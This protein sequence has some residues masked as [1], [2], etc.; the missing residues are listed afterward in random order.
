MSDTTSVP[1]SV[2]T[3]DTPGRLFI[4]CAIWAYEGWTGSFYPPKLPAARR[5]A[6]YGQK[7]TAV[8][9]N[10]TF[11]ALPKPETVDKWVAEVPDGFRFSPKFPKAITHQAGL[12]GAEHERTAFLHLLTRFG[13]KLGAAM[14]QLPPGFGPGRLDTLDRFLHSLPPEL[15]VA[16]E[17]RHLDWFT[18]ENAVRLNACLAQY[19]HVARVIF[20]GR[21]A[22]SSDAEEAVSAQ[23]RKPDVPVVPLATRREVLLRYISSPVWEENMPYLDDWTP[24]LATW[25]AQGHDVHFF[26]HCPKEELS[27]AIARDVYHRISTALVEKHAI[28]LPP[29]PWDIQ[30]RSSENK[31]D[32]DHAD[33]TPAQLALF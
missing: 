7:L 4:G 17:V 31:P 30:A 3:K 12:I 16:V 5:L 8:E 20:D 15:P 10:S 27:P 14:L 2:S 21:P 22:L 24:Q 33:N 9:V 28:M 18:P 26:A 1:T 19:A 11:Y 23:E 29:L 6:S 25:I 13:A 32:D